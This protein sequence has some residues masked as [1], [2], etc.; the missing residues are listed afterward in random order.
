MAFDMK[1]YVDVAE[2]LREF[3][4]KHAKGRIITTV[5]EH[6]EKRVVVKAEVY[7]EAQD[8]WPA[9]VGHSQMA[10]PGTTQFTRGSEMENA[11]TSAVGRALVM[12]GLPSKRVASADEVEW[13]RASAPAQ[14]HAAPAPTQQPDLTAVAASVFGDDVVYVPPA[15]SAPLKAA[16]AFVANTA[17]GQCPKHQQAWVLKPGGVSKTTGKTYNAFWACNGKD[18]DGWCRAKPK[19]SWIAAQERA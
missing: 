13:K 9:G 5:L 15:D 3:Y 2:R 19:A 4:E 18:E 17:D 16:M 8:A 6:T 12:A 11:E 10:I 7:R 14:E 1:D